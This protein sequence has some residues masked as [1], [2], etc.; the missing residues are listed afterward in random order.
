MK[1]KCKLILHGSSK[2]ISAGEFDSIKLAKEWVKD[3]WDKPYTIIKIRNSQI[4]N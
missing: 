1:V 4:K 2:E 3:C